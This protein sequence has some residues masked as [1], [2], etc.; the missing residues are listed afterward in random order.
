MDLRRRSRRPGGKP[1][2]TPASPAR[3]AALDGS[4]VVGAYRVLLRRDPDEEERRTWVGQLQAG[5]TLEAMIS[6]LLE[7]EEFMVRH[8]ELRRRAGLD[9]GERERL[10]IG[11][12]LAALEDRVEALICADEV[13]RADRQRPGVVDR[14]AG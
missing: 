5:V 1:A 12:R 2:P 10:A 7:T 9:A 4:L 13:R 3:P 14:P 6:S 11:R 8:E